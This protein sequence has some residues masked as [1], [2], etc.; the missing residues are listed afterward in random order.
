MTPIR[1][2]CR[3]PI[4]SRDGRPF[5]KDQGNKMRSLVWPTPSVVAG[6]LRTAVGKSAG[7][8]F[9]QQTSVDLFQLQVAG[10]FPVAEDKLYLPAPADC[11]WDGK[12][13]HRARPETLRPGEGTDLDKGL[14]PVTLDGDDFKPKSGPAW[15]PIDSYTSWLLTDDIAFD[16]RFLRSPEPEERTH[17]V[18]DANTGAGSEGQLFSTAAL[19]LTH[20]PRWDAS[21]TE[22]NFD[23]KHAA[24]HLCARA[25]GSGWCGAEVT[26]LDTLHP[27]GGE[28]RLVHWKNDDASAKSWQC[29]DDIAAKLVE[30]TRFRMVLATPAIFDGGWKPGWLNDDL[31]GTVPGTDLKVKLV[32]FSIQRWKAISGWSYQPQPDFDRPGPKPIRRM[33]PAGGVYFFEKLNGNAAVLADRWLQSV[34]DT[35]QDQRDGFGLAC[36]G[37]WKFKEKC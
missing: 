9:S 20:L 8:E 37:T 2:E 11:V 17:V 27:L 28:R 5:G 23:K 12:A 7:K 1:I 31:I 14:Q 25:V 18:M 19:P 4:V 32:G 16:S 33:V 24:I 15:W 30:A 26:H 34:C 6:S 29:P 22:R 21:E 35:E 13:I 3:D 10:V 36:W